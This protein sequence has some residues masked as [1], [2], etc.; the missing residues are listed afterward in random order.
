MIYDFV[1][2]KV[3]PEQLKKDK[4]LYMHTPA[5][6]FM[7]QDLIATKEAYRDYSLGFDNSNTKEINKRLKITNNLIMIIE[8]CDIDKLI[9]ELGHLG[10]IQEDNNANYKQVLIYNLL[11]TYCRN[12]IIDYL[13]LLVSDDEKLMNQLDFTFDEII[14][15]IV[16]DIDVIDD[17]TASFCTH[18]LNLLY[19]YFKKAN[20]V[21]KRRKKWD[22]NYIQGIH[23]IT[24]KIEDLKD[25]SLR[26][27]NDL[28]DIYHYKK[29]GIL[30]ERLKKINKIRKHK[31]E[32]SN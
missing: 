24:F 27:Y 4:Q 3:T 30:H 11:N 1:S 21:A 15:L 19:Y 28:I 16:I 10:D 22:N 17:Q 2:E 9:N 5:T 25:T 12:L 20:I 31:T 18:H 8:Q 6:F 23:H 7:R 29:Y 14:D 32:L 13:L 26:F